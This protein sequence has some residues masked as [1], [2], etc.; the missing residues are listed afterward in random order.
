[1]KPLSAREKTCAFVGKTTT[2]ASERP[3]L[4]CVASADL[5]T[6]TAT[7]EFRMRPQIGGCWDGVL[8]GGVLGGGVPGGGPGKVGAS[9]GQV[10][11]GGDFSPDGGEVNGGGKVNGQGEMS[12]QKRNR[13]QHGSAQGKT[14]TC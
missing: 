6:L 11:A 12:A 8:G 14:T 1:M 13:S 10:L 5:E 2:F 4:A 3:R 9:G 7:R